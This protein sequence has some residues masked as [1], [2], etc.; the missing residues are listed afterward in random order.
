MHSLAS[1]VP[2]TL[3]VKCQ[4]CTVLTTVSLIPSSDLLQAAAASCVVSVLPPPSLFLSSFPPLFFFF[5]HADRG[6]D[7]HLQAVD[8]LNIVYQE[9]SLLHVCSQTME[10]GTV[11]V[12]FSRGFYPKRFYLWFFPR[13]VLGSTVLNIIIVIC[14]VCRPTSPL[15]Q[16]GHCTSL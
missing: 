12:G 2:P 1:L 9:L 16:L 4:Y 5:L 7:R 11:C 15:V 6:A 13:T 14:S 8:V 10:A 3:P